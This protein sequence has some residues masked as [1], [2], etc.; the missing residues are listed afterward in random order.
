M[1]LTV[2]THRV[3]F[4]G[5]YPVWQPPYPKVNRVPVEVEQVGEGVKPPTDHYF[6]PNAFLILTAVGLVEALN[7][8][9]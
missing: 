1:R 8:S 4:H 2:V 7:A 9:L 6:H 3:D 5:G